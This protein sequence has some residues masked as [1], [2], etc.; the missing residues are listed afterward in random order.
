MIATP[1]CADYG[2]LSV[3]LQYRFEMERVLMSR[4]RILLCPR[5]NRGGR[6][7][8]HAATAAHA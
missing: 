8:V 4:R 3:M 5:S 2:R 7:S 6:D 1:S